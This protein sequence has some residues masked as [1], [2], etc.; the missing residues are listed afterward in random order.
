MQCWKSETHVVHSWWIAGLILHRYDLGWLIPF[1]LYL[2]ITL[3]IIFFYVPI[4]IVTKPMYFVW[5]NTP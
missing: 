4:T 5:A 3:R 2:C 1:L